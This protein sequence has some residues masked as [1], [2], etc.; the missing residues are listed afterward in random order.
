LMFFFMIKSKT[1]ML[2]FLT[3]SKTR[4]FGMTP[5]HKRNNEH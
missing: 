2:E 4:F 5:I 1:V 3:L